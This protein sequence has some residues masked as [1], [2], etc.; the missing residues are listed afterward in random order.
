MDR[1]ASHPSVS[2]A[3]SAQLRRVLVAAFRF[4]AAFWTDLMLASARAEAAERLCTTSDAA[5]AARGVTRESEIQRI[6]SSPKG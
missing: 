5:L 3:A 4:V 1:T 6:F 2:L